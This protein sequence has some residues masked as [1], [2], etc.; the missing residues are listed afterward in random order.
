[1]FRYSTAVSN[2]RVLHVKLVIFSV[3][4][5]D[6]NPPKPVISTEHDSHV[7]AGKNFSLTCTIRAPDTNVNLWW[8]MPSKDVRS[9]YFECCYSVQN[10]F[11]I[12]DSTQVNVR[13]TFRSRAV[14]QQLPLHCPSQY[15]HRD[16]RKAAVGSRRVHVFI[17]VCFSAGSH[18]AVIGDH[19]TIRR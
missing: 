17:G 8:R 14:F 10:G 16:G 18:T 1:M 3:S 5:A 2:L 7:V 11:C 19:Q 6:E 4:L 9:L 12:I 13:R 15:A